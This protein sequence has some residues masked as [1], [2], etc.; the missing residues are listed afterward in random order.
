MLRKL[1]KGMNKK[2]LKVNKRQLTLLLALV[3]MLT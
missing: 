3:E 2:T 1:R